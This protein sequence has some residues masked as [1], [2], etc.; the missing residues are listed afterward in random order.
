MGTTVLIGG[1]SC[2]HIEAYYMRWSHLCGEIHAPLHRNYVIVYGNDFP[3]E[4]F[5]ICPNNALM[6]CLL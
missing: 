1:D 3:I 4:I 2:H 6:R 5:A